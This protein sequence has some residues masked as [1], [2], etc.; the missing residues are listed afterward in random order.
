MVVAAAMETG[1]R[2]LRP[3]SMTDWKR[4]F[5]VPIWVSISSMRTM[6]FLISIPTRL[7]RPSSAMKPKGCPKASSPTVTPMM[8][9]GTVSQMISVCLIA[10]KRAMTVRIIMPMKIGMETASAPPARAESSAS[11]PQAMK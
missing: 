4:S 5:P 10:L 6:A 11:P 7:S 8:A 2:R 9:R 3:E 1:I